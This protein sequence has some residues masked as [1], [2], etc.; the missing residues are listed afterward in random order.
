[1][2]LSVN[3]TKNDYLKIILENEVNQIIDVSIEHF[4]LPLI[5]GMSMDLVSQKEF[6]DMGG[7]GPKPMPYSNEIK[8][9]IYTRMYEFFKPKLLKKTT[10]TVNLLLNK[11]L[12]SLSD[13]ELKIKATALKE[14]FQKEKSEKE[15]KPNWNKLDGLFDDHLILFKELEMKNELTNRSK[16]LHDILCPIMHKYEDSGELFV[17]IKLHEIIKD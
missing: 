17:S 16:V 2:T 13:E 5:M 12:N 10:K 9:A 15:I 3:L 8:Q 4:A 11:S 1:M 7:K 14:K 6:Q